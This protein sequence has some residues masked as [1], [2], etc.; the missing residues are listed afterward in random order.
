[1]ELTAL[2]ER[3]NSIGVPVEVVGEGRTARVFVNG[4][5][6]GLVRGDIVIRHEGLI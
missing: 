6:Y 3:F 2:I 5:L 4:R 1:M